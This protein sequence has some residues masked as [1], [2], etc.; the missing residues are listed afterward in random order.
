MLTVGTQGAVGPLVAFGEGLRDAGHD[1]VIGTHDN[2]KEFITRRG[3]GFASIAGDATNMLKEETIDRGFSAGTNPVSY[4]LALRQEAKDLHLAALNVFDK[5]LEV[6]RGADAVMFHDHMF[7]AD[8]IANHYKIHSIQAYNTPVTQ[9]GEISS[10]V[11][12]RPGSTSRIYNH[13]SYYMRDLATW[14][15]YKS[16]LN[17]WRKSRLGMPPLP[18]TGAYREMYSRKVPLLYSV[19]PVLYPKPADWGDWV[20][21]TG[22]WQGEFNHHFDA[23]QGLVDFLST[24]PKPICIGFGSMR[25]SHSEGMTRMLLQALKKNGQRAVILTGWGGMRSAQWPDYVYALP[26]APHDWLYPRVSAVVHHGGVG[27]LMSS[28]RAGIPTLSIYFGGDGILW[29]WRGHQLG[30]GPQPI[31][32]KKVTTERL[33][34]AIHALVNQSSFQDRA[35]QVSIEIKAENGVANAVQIFQNNFTE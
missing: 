8:A 11:G 3:L 1:I 5:S 25:V 2:F 28:L 14:L 27:T 22:Y 12:F 34:E 18:I 19:S 10:Y 21:M 15:P 17:G 33:T 29:A 7:A 13:A 32:F 23:P 20:H 26:E 24:D 30:V 35:K 9:T 16:V 6:C 31:H 4:L